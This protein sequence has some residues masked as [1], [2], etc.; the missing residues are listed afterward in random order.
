VHLLSLSSKAPVVV[1]A[2]AVHLPVAV[3]PFQTP[4]AVVGS[5]AIR[6]AIREER[7]QAVPGIHVPSPNKMVLLLFPVP[8]VLEVNKN[9]V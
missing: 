5:V 4:V 3:Q 9:I 8:V 7:D 2:A 1:Q 6:L